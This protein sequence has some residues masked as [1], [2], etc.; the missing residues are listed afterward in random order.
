MSEYL[1]NVAITFLPFNVHRY[2]VM[3]VTEILAFLPPLVVYAKFTKKPTLIPITQEYRLNKISVVNAVVIAAA[4]VGGQFIM[5][6]LNVPMNVLMET[7]F[8]KVSVAETPIA[9]NISEFCLGILF[10]A[11]VPAVLEEF[12]M[13]GIVFGAFANYSTRLALI[14]TT[15]IFALLHAKFSQV[16]GILFLGFMTG[17]VLIKTNSLAAPVIYHIVN[18]VSALAVGHYISNASCNRQMYLLFGM[19]ILLFIVSFIIFAAINRKRKISKGKYD[20]EL[21][22]SG[23]FSVPVFL[24]VLMVVVNGY[25][26]N[27]F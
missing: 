25:I 27:V 23:M 11:I 17:Y 4:A 15:I 18:N 3:G 1:V 2:I 7:V 6:L 5:L 12:W 14:F 13:R 22:I 24:A 8:H 16:V 10:I 21:V 19:F 20:F 9:G 26:Y